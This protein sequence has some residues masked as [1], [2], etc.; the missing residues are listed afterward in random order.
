MCQSPTTHPRPRPS[1]FDRPFCFVSVACLIIP[2]CAFVLSIHGLVPHASYRILPHSTA[3]DVLLSA[4]APCRAC[5]PCPRCFCCFCFVWTDIRRLS[6][7][8]VIVVHLVRSL[9]LTVW[10]PATVLSRGRSRAISRAPGGVEPDLAPLAKPALLSLT[11]TLFPALFVPFCLPLVFV[12]RG[13]SYV[14]KRSERT[15]T[16]TRRRWSVVLGARYRHGPVPLAAHPRVR[17]E[18]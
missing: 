6:A 16:G 8:A 2:P 1:T 10:R 11:H 13:H 9:L 18:S 15:G 7:V 5:I 3:G 17:H 4:A 12:I 14:E